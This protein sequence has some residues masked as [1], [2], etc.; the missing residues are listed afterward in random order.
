M[1]LGMFSLSNPWII[2]ALVITALLTLQGFGLLLPNEIRIYRELLSTR[3]NI[4]K[5]A[6]LGMINAKVGGVQGVFQL[7]II[8]IMVNLRF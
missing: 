7:A 1:R 5:I 6:K 2:A 3:P 8:F 4:D